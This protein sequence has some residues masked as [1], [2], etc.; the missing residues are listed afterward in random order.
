MNVTVGGRANIVLVALFMALAGCTTLPVATGPREILDERTGDTLSVVEAPWIFA[1]TRTDVAAN[2]RDYVQL[3]AAEASSA[4]KYRVYLVAQF[5]STVDRRMSPYP[6]ATDGK[7]LIQA[8]GR[9][10]AFTPVQPFP[11]LFSHRNDLFAPQRTRCITWVYAT[12]LATLEYM[13]ESSSVSLRLS[14][15]QLQL[16]YFTWSDAQSDL[17][18]LVRTGAG[19]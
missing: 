6:K 4:G 14:E 16:P 11:T 12:D 15:Q 9:E 1:R 2:A 17:L 10:I 5:W 7:L 3:V 18:S 19:R 8:D 13:A